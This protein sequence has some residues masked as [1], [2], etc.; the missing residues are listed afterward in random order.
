M[1]DATCIYV[2]LR[3]V[4]DLAAHQS[5]HRNA[6]A[7]VAMTDASPSARRAPPRDPGRGR[8]V[9][10]PARGGPEPGWPTGR[11]RRPCCPRRPAAYPYAFLFAS[12]ARPAPGARK[13]HNLAQATCRRPRRGPRASLRAENS[14]LLGR[15]RLRPTPSDIK[16]TCKI[17]HERLKRA[18][19]FLAT[20]GDGRAPTSH[21]ARCKDR[22]L[23]DFSFLPE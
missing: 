22:T 20:A 16:G 14:L 1:L 5:Y 10:A 12:H 15:A 13:T 21:S 7:T 17:E 11:V 23:A 4:V 18:P 3:R 8:A 6:E 2:G 9:R 19:R